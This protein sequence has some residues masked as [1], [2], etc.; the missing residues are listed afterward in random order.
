MSDESAELLQLDSERYVTARSCAELRNARATA[1]KRRS[2]LILT[3]MHAV[4][5]AHTC[6]SCIVYAAALSAV[7]WPQC[8]AGCA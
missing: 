7:I 8:T 6:A 3:L 5:A 2:L 1:G 4:H